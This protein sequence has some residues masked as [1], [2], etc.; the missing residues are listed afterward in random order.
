MSLQDKCGKEFDIQGMN[1]CRSEMHSD[2]QA[3][4]CM[5]TALPSPYGQA[6][7]PGA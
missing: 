5:V 4:A 1:R 7:F 6:A 2:V 3:P